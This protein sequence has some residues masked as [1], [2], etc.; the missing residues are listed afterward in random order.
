MKISLNWLQELVDV[1]LPASELGQILTMAGFEVEDII[2]L[3]ELAAGV[4][5]GKILACDPHPNADKLQVCRV[6]IGEQEPT[7]IV[8]GAPNARADI[9][10]PVATL[11]SYLPAVDLKIKPV[12]LRGVPSRGMICSLAELGLAKESAGI[13]I[14]SEENLSLG[15]DVRP[16]LGL[17]DVILDLTTTANRADALSMVGV[18]REVAALTQAEFKL[19][20]VESQS[21]ATTPDLAVAV[22]S[23]VPCSIYMATKITNLNIGPSPQWLRSRLQG[24][25]IRAINNVVDVTNYILLEWGQPLHAFDSKRLQKIGGSASLSMGVR[26]AQESESLQT[27][28]GNQRKLSEQNLIITANNVPVALAGVMGGEETEVNEN[29]TEIVLEAAIFDPVIVR[30]SARNQSLRTEASSRYERGVNYAEFPL[31][32]ARAIALITELA[33]GTVI[34]QATAGRIEAKPRIITLRHWRLQAILGPVTQGEITLGK[35]EEILTAL[36]CKLKTSSEGIW[37]VEV[38]PYRHRDLEREIDL[39]EEVARLY[40]YDNFQAELPQNSQ[41]GYLSSREK[42]KRRLRS[43]C[44]GVG[45]TEVVHYSLVSKTGEE[46]VINNPLF[47]EYSALRQNLLTGLIEACAYNVSQ[48]N[49]VLNAIEIGRV[50]YPAK[51]QI[52]EAEIVAGILGGDRHST[53]RWVEGGKISPMSW[54]EAKG[55]LESILTSLGL[56]VEYRPLTDDSRLHPGRTA[57]LWLEGKYLGLF[58]QLHPQLVAEKDLPPAVYVFE[59]QLEL[60]LTVLNQSNK[61]TPKFQAFSTY[62][63]VARDL[64]FFAPETLTVAELSDLMYSTAGSLLTEV[65][66]FDQYQGE[67]VPSEQRSLAFSLVYRA[68]DRTLTEAEIEPIH[69]KIREALVDKF[70][71][72]L[73]S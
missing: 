51:E 16:L 72:A 7:N 52:E 70:S 71:V 23:A 5:V 30:R 21:W 69:Q 26:Q 55:I 20:Q 41:P 58:G 57:S 1:K 49:G 6:D 45:L 25:G 53:G 44:R 3:R 68:A 46:A 43:L 34:S 8:C 29:T 33:G 48:G 10:V 40:G 38:P 9:L 28:D 66:L 22:E 56:Q 12:K 18:A 60:L 17:D 13:H 50:F 63:G 61:I 54:Y 2:D 36:G 24:A 64:A 11:G 47:Q 37:Q 35:V 14:F 62:P 65:E 39:V 73:R 32:Q 67:N 59:W 15:T 31:A 19:P 42:V 4:V 27:L